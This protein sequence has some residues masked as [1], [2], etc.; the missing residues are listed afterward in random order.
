MLTLSWDERG[1]I[2]EHYMPRGNTVNNATYADLRNHLRPAIKS[3][4]CALLSTGVLLQHDNAGPHTAGST[5][6]TIRDLSF[7]CLPHP[8]YSPDLDPS[9][10]HV[11][12]PLKEATKRCSRR[13]MSGC[14]L[15]QK[16][17]FCRGIQ[18]LPKRWNTCMVRSGDGVEKWRHCVPYV[19]NKL[20]DKN[21]LRFSFDSPTHFIFTSQVVAGPCACWQ[22]SSESVY[23][24]NSHINTLAVCFLCGTN[25]IV[26]Y[27]DELV[28]ILAAGGA[29]QP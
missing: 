21:Y 13:C 1:V 18:A 24:W 23:R 28:A 11:F 16:T 29:S 19:F 2:L 5:V 3:K 9:D 20:L 12:G 8:P 7:E 4:R 17:F 22:L 10:F 27:I 26:T 25:W 14:A 15:S 6:P